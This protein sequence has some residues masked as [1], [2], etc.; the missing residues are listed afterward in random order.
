MKTWVKN[1]KTGETWELDD[2]PTKP[3][4]EKDG[5]TIIDLKQLSLFRFYPYNPDAAE[6]EKEG[7]QFT[8]FDF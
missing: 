2:D 7:Y 8:L 4:Y 6:Q 1:T 5:H 3:V